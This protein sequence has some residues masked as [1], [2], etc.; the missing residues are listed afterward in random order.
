MMKTRKRFSEEWTR[1]YV[2][3]IVLAL[4]FIHAMGYCPPNHTTAATWRLTTPDSFAHRD[5]KPENILIDAFGHVK[6]ADFGLCTGFFP[7]HET[8]FFTSLKD[9]P[10]E[11]RSLLEF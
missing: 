4:K 7:T 3:E 1:F 2:A 8:A 11:V 6:I 5:I 9:A 10:P